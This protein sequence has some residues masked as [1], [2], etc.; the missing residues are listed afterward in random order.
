VDRAGP[1]AYI[2]AIL[3][4][5]ID[6][7]AS[8]DCRFAAL[9]MRKSLYAIKNSVRPELSHQSYM[10]SQISLILSLSKDASW[11]CSASSDAAPARH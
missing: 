2:A 9:R 6:I 1:A 10:P 5:W 11:S 3:D 4:D 7:R 8:F